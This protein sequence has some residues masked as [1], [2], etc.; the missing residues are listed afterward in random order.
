MNKN[1]LGMFKPKK[2]QWA[3]SCRQGAEEA[4]G[5][6]CWAAA[7]S[8]RDS[9][10]YNQTHAILFDQKCKHMIWRSYAQLCY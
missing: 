2:Q 3:C 4:Q 9:C 6:G 7:L 8:T 5:W 1:M 10:L